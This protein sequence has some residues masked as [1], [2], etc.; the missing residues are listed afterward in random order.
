VVAQVA[1]QAVTMITVSVGKVVI[2]AQEH[3]KNQYMGLQMVRYTPCVLLAHQTVAAAV[4][5]TKIVV[6]DA[7]VLL[8][9]LV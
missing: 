9:E 6:M 8:M 2:T 3:C 1:H 5:V 4:H 7:Q